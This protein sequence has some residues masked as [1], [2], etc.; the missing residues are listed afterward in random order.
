MKKLLIKLLSVVMAFTL[1]MGSIS[2]DSYAEIS[3]KMKKHFTEQPE[4]V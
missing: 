3:E 2:V 1:V 4:V